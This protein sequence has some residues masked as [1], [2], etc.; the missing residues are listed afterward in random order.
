LP[1]LHDAL[2]A[3]QNISV[4]F[5]HLTDSRLAVT[6][7]QLGCLG[8]LFYLVGGQKFSGRYNPHGNPSYTQ[9][10]TQAIRTFRITGGPAQPL[11]QDFTEITDSQELHRRDYN[12]AEQVFPDGGFGFTVF[13]GVFRPSADLPW[14][15][16]VNIRDQAYQAIPETQFGQRFNQYHGAKMSVYDPLFNE[17]HTVFFGGIGMYTWDTINLAA[18]VDSAVPFVRTI[19]VV[20]RFSDNTL[21]ENVLP[22]RMPG[23]LGASAEFLPLESA[24]RVAGEVLDLEQI[25]YSLS[26]VGHIFGGIESNQPNI[27]MQAAG[28][29]H[30]TNRVFKVR[31]GRPPFGLE[32]RGMLH[33]LPAFPNPADEQA[34][35]QLPWMASHPAIHLTDILAR[36]HTVD[37]QLSNNQ[38]TM[39]TASLSP[40]IYFLRV[41][42]AGQTALARMVVQH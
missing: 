27:F 37:V 40:G 36:Q 25:G 10:Y 41:S 3:N 24:P 4:A 18:M 11:I 2:L 7:G 38:L 6:G 29:S 1:A 17:M 23:L 22:V 28:S 21:A 14:H 42:E 12:M 13:S 26:P 15:N 9:T 31:I 16:V 30:A 34:R 20:T 8:D 35:V 32:E 19:S 39:D 5:S 33:H